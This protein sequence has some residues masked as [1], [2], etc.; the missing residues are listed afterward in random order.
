MVIA[1]FSLDMKKLAAVI[2]FDD[3]S[4]H[5]YTYEFLRVFSPVALSKSKNKPPEVY[6]KKQVKLLLIESVAKHGYRFTFDDGHVD[7]YSTEYLLM[8]RDTQAGLWSNYLAATNNIGH[9]REA[10]IDIKQL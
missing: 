6:H 3:S 5:S 8:L 1:K 7:I 10:S 2:T 4:E 9:S